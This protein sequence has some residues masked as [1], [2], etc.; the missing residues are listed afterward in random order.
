MLMLALFGCAGV[1]DM[2]RATPLQPGQARFAAG[3]ALGVGA[4]SSEDSTV[5]GPA[6]RVAASAHVGVVPGVE[7]GGGVGMGVAT[8]LFAVPDVMVD[9]KVR[10]GAPEAGRFHKSLNPRVRWG[11]SGS[12]PIFEVDLPLL[13][14]WDVGRGQVV[15]GPHVG[16]LGR[17]DDV[18]VR[19]QAGLRAGW[20]T[21]AG[22]HL[23]IAPAVA[24]DWLGSFESPTG[25]GVAVSAGVNFIVALE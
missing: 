7:L 6:G 14:G 18:D 5:S 23:E 9:A 1:L 3:V 2:G 19:V 8:G 16:A 13:L 10:L 20:V 11:L 24:L 25:S 12:T 15:F 21:A 22:P 4:P 17:L